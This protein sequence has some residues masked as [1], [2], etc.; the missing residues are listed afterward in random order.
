MKNWQRQVIHCILFLILLFA[1]VS[2][3]NAKEF[4][5]SAG[6][7]GDHITWTYDAENKTMTFT[8]YGETYGIGGWIEGEALKNDYGDWYA[9]KDKVEKVVLGE[10][11]TEIHSQAFLE[12]SNLKEVEFP[13][14]LKK[15]GSRAFEG[16]GVETLTFPPALKKIEMGAFRACR[17]ETLV[18]PSTLSE[19]GEDAFCSSYIRKIMGQS[20][21]LWGNDPVHAH[22]ILIVA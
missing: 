13:S 16:C 14:T 20:F 6:I 2:M 3:V 19:I 22:Y 7:G 21:F 12:C 8:G 11:I 5:T 1:S 18:I 15:I 4:P 10:G 9:L 17:V